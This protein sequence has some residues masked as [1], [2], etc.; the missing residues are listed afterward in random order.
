MIALI[1]ARSINNVIG[2][3]GKIPWTIEG[4]QKEFKELTTGNIVIMGRKTFQEIGHPLPNR[5]TIV[6]S[7]NHEFKGENLYSAKSVKEA[8]KIAASISMNCKKNIYF[9]GG[10]KI[11][12]EALPLVD[13]MYITQIQLT[14]EEGDTF[15]PNFDQNDFYIT[16]GLTLGDKIKYTRFIYTR[17]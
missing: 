17:K 13:T 3:N 8:L 14:I 15:F 9:A 6:L 1:A 4:E 12:K 10:Y 5:T 16:Q 2:K 7:K 11:Y